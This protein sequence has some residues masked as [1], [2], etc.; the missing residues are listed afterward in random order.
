MVCVAQHQD[1]ADVR[2]RGERD[3]TG[4]AAGGEVTAATVVLVLASSRRNE[5][6]S[7]CTSSCKQDESRAVQGFMA[8]E[9]VWTSGDSCMFT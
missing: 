1:G 9:Y 3:A 7:R 5:L 6:H 2:A 4:W 8:D